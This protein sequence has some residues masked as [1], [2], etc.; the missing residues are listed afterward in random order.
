MVVVVCS[1]FGE[2]RDIRRV[3]G[4]RLCRHFLVVRRFCRQLIARAMSC[5]HYRLDSMGFGKTLVSTPRFIS[6]FLTGGVAGGSVRRGEA[7]A[8][9]LGLF[10]LVEDGDGKILAADQ[11][12]ALIV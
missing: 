7:A 12:H 5:A 3:G 6:R 9:V 11:A 10:Q 2:R 8:D 1:I 4:W